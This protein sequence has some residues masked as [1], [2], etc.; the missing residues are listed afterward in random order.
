MAGNVKSRN[1]D[2]NEQDEKG[3]TVLHRL[4]YDKFT[5]FYISNA[6]F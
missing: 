1:V 2:I 3:Q 5:P 4:I 6:D